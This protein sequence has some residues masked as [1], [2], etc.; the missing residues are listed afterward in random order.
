MTPPRPDERVWFDFL[1]GRLNDEERQRFEAY[2]QQHP[3]EARQCFQYERLLAECAELPP[4]TVSDSL[5]RQA[6]AGLM[7]RIHELEASPLEELRPLS[8]RQERRPSLRAWIT[9]LTTAA[10]LILGVLIGSRGTDPL[11]GPPPLAEGQGRPLAMIDG[12]DR[13]GYGSTPRS[14]HVAVKGLQVA[15]EGDVQILLNETNSYEVN[16][17]VSSERIQSYLSYILRNDAD[18]ERRRQ[19]VALL[20][21]HCSGPEICSVLVYALTQDPAPAVRRAA[22]DALALDSGDPL[23]RQSF[24]KMAVEDPSAELR[25]LA[26]RVLEADSRRELGR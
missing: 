19:S 25:E 16:G 10:A 2:L 23:V 6:R 5:L 24:F 11:Q 15:S 18:P 13:Y 7:S 3:A 20:D 9:P 8:R 26:A 1:E 12:T 22:A 4:P 21:A 17:P 14:R